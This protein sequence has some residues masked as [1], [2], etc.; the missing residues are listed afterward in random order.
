[1][2][3]DIRIKYQAAIDLFIHEG[4]VQWNRYNAML[5]VNTALFGLIT[6]SKG[7][8]PIL[9]FLSP[10]FGL[11]LCNYWK[12][13]TM[14]GFTWMSHWIIEANK[15][16]K[17]LGGPIDPVVNGEELGKKIG[18]GFT[19]NAS[20]WIIKIFVFIYIIIFLYNMRI[21]WPFVQ[22]LLALY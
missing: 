17:H 3:D 21:F 20:L 11:I 2:K 4:Q 16:E 19:K 1:M 7:L 14:R 9:I 6:L 15:L 10:I 13:M 18:T 8:P 12:G 22:F 5:V